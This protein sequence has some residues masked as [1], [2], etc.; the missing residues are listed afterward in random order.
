[1]E[2]EARVRGCFNKRIQ[3][4]RLSPTDE[5]QK[6][7]GKKK[8]ANLLD[9]KPTFDLPMSFFSAC[10]SPVGLNLSGANGCL[11]ERRYPT[12]FVTCSISKPHSF[13]S[14]FGNCFLRFVW[15]LAFVFWNFICARHI[16]PRCDAYL[17]ALRRENARTQSVCHAFPRGALERVN[18][19]FL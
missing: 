14:P 16:A 12:P 6:A 17:C 11:P 15:D 18:C 19:L 1:M 8:T 3:T 9:P 13:F 2:A 4:D 5:K 7:K 10:F